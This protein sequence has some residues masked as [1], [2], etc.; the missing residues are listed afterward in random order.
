MFALLQ[1]PGLSGLLFRALG[2][3]VVVG[4]VVVVGR[5]VLRIAWRLVTVAAAVVALLLAAMLF[6]PAVL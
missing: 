1:I 3:L 4:V 5:V 6:L 2:L